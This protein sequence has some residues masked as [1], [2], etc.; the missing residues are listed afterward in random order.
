MTRPVCAEFLTPDDALAWRGQW[1]G[2]L[3]IPY[4]TAAHRTWWFD[5]AY[6]TAS[7]AVRHP[8]I[9]WLGGTLT[10][11]GRPECG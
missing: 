7:T 11:H 2:W 9:A 5:A 1:G 10:G 8:A 3:F 6:Y 4:D